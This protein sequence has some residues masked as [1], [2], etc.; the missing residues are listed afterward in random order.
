MSARIS[1]VA[2]L[3][4]LLILAAALI[5][6]PE[7]SPPGEGRPSDPLPPALPDGA[8]ARLGARRL[9]HS[10]HVVALAVSPDGRLVVTGDTGGAWQPRA[11]GPRYSSPTI[12]LW[13]ARTGRPVGSVDTPSQFRTLDF[14]ADGKSLLVAGSDL[15]LYDIVGNRLRL[16]S[17]LAARTGNHCYRFRWAEDG[18]S[19][20]AQDELLF[21]G[22]LDIEQWDLATGLTT[23]RWVC[24]EEKAPLPGGGS[25]Q[26]RSML[27]SPDRRLLACRMMRVN[28]DPTRPAGGERERVKI[29]DATTGKFLFASPP[30]R[31]SVNAAFSPDGR[32]LAVGGSPVR[33]LDTETG[34]QIRQFP[35]GAGTFPRLFFS[36]DSRRLLTAW[37][38]ASR[39]DFCSDVGRIDCWDLSSAAR[40]RTLWIGTPDDGGANNGDS[41]LSVA[42]GRSPLRHA[43]AG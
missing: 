21:H 10:T 39:I 31:Y 9:W 18:K 43:G 7:R 6:T 8:V 23:H 17:K 38:D 29:Y 32:L 34:M 27:L 4:G 25:E 22:A 36:P 2:A 5:R 19:V 30:D 20:I 11:E 15:L 37:P 1:L 12:H 33:I 14:S 13:D 40:S 28:D 26:A 16:R 42:C 24:P 41:V 35:T 3:L